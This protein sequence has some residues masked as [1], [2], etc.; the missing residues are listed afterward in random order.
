VSD[1]LDPG[2]EAE[3]IWPAVDSRKWIDT[4]G[5]AFAARYIDEL[6]AQVV[7]RGEAHFHVSG[8]GHEITAVLAQHLA[9]T[10]WL[11]LHYRD[12][13]LLLARGVPFEQFFLSLLARAGSHSDGRQ[14]SAHFSNR[15]LRV[16]SIVGPVGNNSL[17]AVGVAAAIRDEPD[18]PLVV[19][20]VGDGTTQQGEFLEAVA[21]AVR[22]NVPVLFLVENNTL[23]I[24][25]VTSGRT[26]FDLP[27]GPASSFMG[28]DIVRADVERP[29]EF[30]DELAAIVAGMRRDRKPRLC[31]LNVERLSDHTNSDDQTIYR[32]NAEIVDGAQRDPLKVLRDH[33]AKL[34]VSASHIRNLEAGIRLEIDAALR[35]AQ[36]A[37]SPEPSFDTPGARKGGGEGR[38]EYRGETSDRTVVMRDAIRGVLAAHLAANPR[39]VL[40]GQDIEDPKGDVFGVTRGL[41]S[42]YP[43]RVGNAA[44]SEATIVG[45]AI[46]RALA[47]QR[48]VAFMQFADFIP[49]ALNQ[50]MSELATMSW[51]TAGAWNVPVVIMASCGG[52]RPGLGPF[53]AQTI[54]ATLAHIPGIDVVMP[55]SAADA[56]GLLNNALTSDRPTV[57]L[58]PKALLNTLDCATSTDLERHH[59]PYGAA[60]FLHEGR[61]LTLV[62]YGNGIVHCAEVVKILSDA[63]VF[64]DLIDLRSLSPW[65]IESV[66]NS[67][68]KT[69]RLVV[70]HEDN[71]SVGFGAEVISSVVESLDIPIQAKRVTRPDTHVPFNFP[72]QTAILPSVKTILETCASLVGLKA[73]WQEALPSD[74]PFIAIAAIGSGPADD[75]I[76]IRDL[77]CREGQHIKI[78]DPL[79]VVEATK[80]AVE[81]A[82]TTDGRIHK[83]LCGVDETVKV[84][85]AI[86][87]IEPTSAVHDARDRPARTIES[88]P[89]LRRMAVSR[90]AFQDQRVG[91][92]VPVQISALA[93]RRGSKVVSNE[94]MTSLFP[95]RTAQEIARLTGIEERRWAAPG[96]TVLSLAVDATRDLMRQLN[97]KVS[98]L[99]LVIASTSTADA[100]TPSLACRVVASLAGVTGALRVPAFDVN[101]ACS[102]YL[103]ALALAHDHVR[104]FPAAKVL[105]VTS[106]VLSPL[107]DQEDFHTAAIFADAATA[108]LV[109]A[110][111]NDLES[112]FGLEFQRPLLSGN[113]ESGTGLSV[114]VVGNGSISMNGRTVFSNAVRTMQHMMI[115]ACDASG[116]RADD[117]KLV[118]PHQANQRILDALGSRL[119]VP[120]A[121][122]IGATGNTGSSSIPLALIEQL[123]Q[124]S[125]GDHIGLVAFGG[126]FTFAAATGRMGSTLTARR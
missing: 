86:V 51:R 83:V 35:S 85:D 7:R 39:V 58:Y 21:E 57:F 82:S 1:I 55:S 73:E 56:A 42:R 9:A 94:A 97:M 38:P 22:A 106:E 89:V 12:K 81:I 47:G 30:S 95:Q 107:L 88:R 60:H 19:C 23:S 6:E 32:Q 98:E 17:Q 113:P 68:R 66:V 63:D 80:A 92:P 105:V 34:E 10:D 87:L 40:L 4:Y 14:M 20:C 50:I 118:I 59:V 116:L 67:A 99:D 13:A 72:N 76:I 37:A 78:G 77:L 114:P 43:G 33:L 44:L 36:S 49:L 48:P 52:Y 125:A 29:Q 41:S 31:V 117:L 8:A 69:R 45:T 27:T 111:G 18:S 124:L 119:S 122:T 2:D 64:C 121:S 110:G 74:S 53:H 115:S 25:T 101:A 5:F 75:T 54:E 100:A 126:G 103:F 15:N 96:E 102:G 28:L 91:E 61:D 11:H 24:S 65:D 71:R 112:P 70:V 3:A 46:G 93:G 123:S 120:V 104:Q 62:S 108:T 16:L 109:C 26:F 84:G 90:P 79:V